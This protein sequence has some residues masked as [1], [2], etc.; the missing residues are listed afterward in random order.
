VILVGYFAGPKRAKPY[1]YEGQVKQELSSAAG[2]GAGA[3]AGAVCNLA[4]P[5]PWSLRTGPRRMFRPLTIQ[6]TIQ[7]RHCEKHCASLRKEYHHHACTTTTTTAPRMVYVYRHVSTS[8]SS[9]RSIWSVYTHIAK[10][11]NTNSVCV[12]FHWP[13][14][15]HSRLS[16]STFRLS[17]DARASTFPSS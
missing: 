17:V 9:G 11:A 7:W 4:I 12:A 1:W 5:C 10:P 6:V 8:L 2:A 16:T 3:V 15:G 13:A 14:P